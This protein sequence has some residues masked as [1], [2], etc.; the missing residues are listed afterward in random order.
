MSALGLRALALVAASI[1]IIVL[2]HRQNELPVIRAGLSAAAWPLQVLV[3]SPFAAFDYLS[4]SFATRSRLA[5]ENAALAARLSAVDI[6]V[7]RLN[8]SVSLTK[9][10]GGGWSRRDASRS[11]GE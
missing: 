3:N 8:A 5:A 9:A 7:R 11:A 2:D 4:E 6:E 10:L 1:S